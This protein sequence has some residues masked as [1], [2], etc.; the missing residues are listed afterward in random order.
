MH[1]KKGLILIGAALVMACILCFGPAWAGSALIEDLGPARMDWQTRTLTAQ[2][3]ADA[4]QSDTEFAQNVYQIQVRQAKLRARK[5]L[6]DGLL[7]VRVDGEQRVKDILQSGLQRTKD[8][9]RLVQSSPIERIAPDKGPEPESSEEHKKLPAYQARFSLSGPGAALCIPSELWYAQKKTSTFT[10]QG[11]DLEGKL[12]FTGLIVD[13]RGLGGK[14]A[15]VCRLFDEH[16][17]LVYG[18]SLVSR[19][20]GEDQGMVVYSSSMP[21]ARANSRAGKAPLEVRARNR[22]P[23]SRTDFVVQA[24]DIAPLWRANN[25]EVFRQGKVIIVLQEEGGEQVVEYPLDEEA[26]IYEY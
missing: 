21:Q 12:K 15:L 5:A 23:D 1:T 11:E 2:G 7:R 24:Q 8:L 13:A 16:D 22:H 17:K 4:A 6:W 26:E 25:W 14:P 18:P 20:I 3:Q 10:A 9:R 19:Q